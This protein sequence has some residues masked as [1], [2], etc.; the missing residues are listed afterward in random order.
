M[1]NLF[2]EIRSLDSMKEDDSK[3]VRTIRALVIRFRE[4]KNELRVF[5]S[6]S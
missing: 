3:I 5:Y 2:R 1:N 4:K 6:L